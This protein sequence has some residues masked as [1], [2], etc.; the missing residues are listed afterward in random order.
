MCAIG[1]VL[2]GACDTENRLII[3]T[4]ENRGRPQ[5]GGI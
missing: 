1:D 4:E 3:M 2:L 5:G